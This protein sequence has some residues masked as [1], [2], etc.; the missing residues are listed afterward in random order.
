[1]GSWWEGLR[2][3]WFSLTA[4]QRI[5]LFG[6]SAIVLGGLI[7]LAL[8]AS[9]PTYALLFSRL[10]AAEASRIVEE[11]QKEKIPYRLRDG[12]SS[13]YV[14]SDRV[15]ELRVRLAGKGLASGKS[16]GYELLDGNGLGMTDFMQRVNLKRAIEGELSRTISNLEQVEMARV[17]LVVPERA[18]FQAAQNVPSA[19]VVVKLRPGMALSPAQIEGIAA[20]V[21]GSVE[22]LTVEN[23]TILDT[24]GNLLSNTAAR[25]PEFSAAS[26][27]IKYQQELEA[28]LTQKGQSMLDNVLGRGNS[29]VRV[30]AEVD[31]T[32]LVQE[33]DLIDPESQT[34]ISEETLDEQREAPTGGA[35]GAN[36]GAGAQQRVANMVRNYELSRTRERIEHG[37]GQIKRLSVSVILNYRRLTTGDPNTGGVRYEPYSA[38]ELESFADL[39]R[40]AVGFQSE[41]GDELSIQQIRFDTS[42]D[43]QLEKELQ[44][45]QRRQQQQQY[46]RYGLIALGLV[47]AFLLVLLL[48]RRLGQRVE[49]YP[50]SSGA[51]LPP[52]QTVNLLTGRPEPVLEG[53]E[54]GDYELSEDMFIQ[55]LSPEARARVRAKEKMMEEI[56]SFVEQEPDA[57]TNLIRTW[58]VEDEV[59]AQRAR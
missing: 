58:L 1:M 39:V 9:R 38:Q 54:S 51:P 46:L 25:N 40:K 44:A 18:P 59:H 24:R 19:S 55:R 20:L 6:V 8:W 7:A 45:W 41:R 12:G 49:P 13:I 17:H 22:G 14:P 53:L 15:Y 32:R 29:L 16:L 57:A 34:V 37:V 30:S 36:A 56:R 33:R 5:S 31:F 47:L 35:T 10:E 43:E 42:A 3:F 4:A 28:Y 52:G 21:A 2:R 11:L 23:V 26:A 50:L 48:V 27:Q